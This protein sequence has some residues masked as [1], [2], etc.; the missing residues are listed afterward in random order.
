M[1]FKQNSLGICYYFA[2]KREMRF[3]KARVFKASQPIIF[4]FFSFPLVKWKC[5]LNFFV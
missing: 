5:S 2:I 4:T 1:F 3:S